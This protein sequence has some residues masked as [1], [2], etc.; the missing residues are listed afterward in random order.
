MVGIIFIGPN[1]G[2]AMVAWISALLVG[3]AAF[4]T[5][6]QV[7]AEERRSRSILVL[8]QSDLRGPFYYSVF[9]GLRSVLSADD[10]SHITIY[11]E[12]LD[13]N[14]FRGKNHEALLQRYLKEKYQ[15]VPIGVVVAAGAATL[16]LVLRWRSELWPEVPVVFAMVDEI[17]FGRL[18]LP[19]G[20]TGNIVKVPLADSV[21]AARTLVPDLQ[22]VAFVGDAW[23]GLTVYRNWKGEIPI[24]TGGLKV[25]DLV[26]QTMAEV[27]KQVAHLP[28]RSAIIYS[29]MFSDGDGT[30][31]PPATAVGLVAEKANR[32]IV[33]AAETFLAPGGTGGFVILP[34][35]MGEEAARLVLRILHGEPASSMA[36]AMSGAV[37]PVFNWLQ[38][39]RWGVR[40]SDLPSGSEIRFREPGQ[41]EKYRWQTLAVAAVLLIQAGLIWVLLHER[42]MRADAERES[43][44]HLSELAH[45]NRQATAGELSSTMAHE[46]NQPLGAILTNTE[47]AELI[48]SSPAPNLSEVKEI[49]AD[50]KRDDIRASEVID[51]MRGFLR[52]APFEDKAIDL[53]DAVRKVFDFL[54]VQASARNVALSF[55]PSGEPLQV[56]GDQVQIQQVIMNLVVNSMDAM[57]AIPN[58]RSVIGRT[59]MNGGSSAVVS[60]ADSGPGIPAEKLN[61]IFDPFFTTKKQGMGIGLSISRTIVQAHKGRIWAENQREGGAV[62]RLSLPLALS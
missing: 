47:T 4:L 16:E 36:P 61:E 25:I 43:R 26:G 34:G 53:N 41:W 40:D 45:A 33:V 52:R 22:T 6:L 27:R 46:L 20:V 11:T 14:R 50:I 44:N 2:S 18:R 24:A 42:H 49:L 35:R 10:R 30:Y 51:R 54:S 57:A 32:P 8:D 9:S 19:D 56:R 39:Q 7:T 58:G 29:A 55:E 23:D 31:Y 3:V 5:P 37:K 17:D 12:S 60:I 59:E 62:F 15:G 38:M 13:L 1:V 21:K 48:L 28:D